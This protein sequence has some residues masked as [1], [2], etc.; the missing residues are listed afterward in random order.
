MNRRGADPQRKMRRNKFTVFIT[1][2]VL[3]IMVTAG[4]GLPQE[5]GVVNAESGKEYQA[6]LELFKERKYTEAVPHFQKAYELDERNTAALFAHG[7][8]LNNMKKYMEASDKLKLVLDKSPEHEKAL[9]LYPITLER[10]SQNEKAL[11]A[12]DKGIKIKPDNYNFYWGKGRIY[13]KQKKYKDALININRAL[14]LNPDYI[15]IMF[16][17]AQTLIDLGR[18]DEGYI[19]ANKILAKNPNHAR[20][21]IIAADY[22][23]KAG[24]LKEALADYSAAAKNIETKAYAEHYIGVIKQELEEIDIEKE[25]EAR[26]KQNRLRKRKNQQA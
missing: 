20:A 10:D 19:T 7:L 8:A 17:R 5:S 24:K 6:G 3:L 23:R 22:K 2:I 18:T 26:Q 12:Y 1:A 11:A 4:A 14:E 16:L 13:L 25:F 9:L 15:K 21:R